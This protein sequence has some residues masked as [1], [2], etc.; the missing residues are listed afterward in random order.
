MSVFRPT[1]LCLPADKNGEDPTAPA[2]PNHLMEYDIRQSSVF[3]RG[4]NV[5]VTN[6]FGTIVVN[7]VGP[8]TLMVP[9]TKNLSVPPPPPAAPDVDHFKCYKLRTPM[10]APRF[11]AVPNVHVIDQFGSATITLVQ[12]MRLCAPAD[13]NGED[14]GAETHEAH[15]LCYKIRHVTFG[16]TAVLVNNQFGPQAWDVIRR[17]EFCVPSTTVPT[18]GSPSGAFV[19]AARPRR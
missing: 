8:A 19:G 14:P 4:N 18:G 13:K 7:V 10:G 6:Q 15:L 17:T 5:S 1:N 2:D 3:T 11:T 12:P 9:T 16:Q